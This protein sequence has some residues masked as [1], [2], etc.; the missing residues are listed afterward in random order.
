MNTW[1]EVVTF[2]TGLSLWKAIVNMGTGMIVFVIGLLSLIGVVIWLLRRGKSPTAEPGATGG[3]GTGTTPP[4]QSSTPKKG[5][6][7]GLVVIL[8]MLLVASVM[9]RECISNS[10][11]GIPTSSVVISFIPQTIQC[12]VEMEFEWILPKGQTYRGVNSD[13]MLV[14]DLKY[15]G[16]FMSFK[17]PFEHDGRM[18]AGIFCLKRNGSGYKGSWSQKAHSDSG[19]IELNQTGCMEWRGP[20]T[21]KTGRTMVAI[22]RPRTWR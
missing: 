4:N 16:R 1:N 20:Y 7:F 9:F 17:I 22:L 6:G 10:W 14:E 19:S 21:D 5:F 3:S 18:D 11:G 15:D 8:V 13:V 12:G 2:V